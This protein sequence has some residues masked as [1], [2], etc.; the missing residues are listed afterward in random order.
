MRG[1]RTPKTH[2]VPFHHL[3]LAA[4]RQRLERFLYLP[5]RPA[6]QRTRQLVLGCPY[7]LAGL[8]DRGFDLRPVTDQKEGGNL[9]IRQV[10]YDRGEFI[11]GREEFARTNTSRALQQ[12]WMTWN[13]NMA[14][15]DRAGPGGG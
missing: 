4:E 1:R 11:D 13:A 6:F 9:A 14:Q 8:V 7:L 15:Q 2:A 5:R 10:C 3:S 12:R